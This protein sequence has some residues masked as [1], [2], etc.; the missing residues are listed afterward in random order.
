MWQAQPD[1]GVMTVYRAEE[2]GQSMVFING[3]STNDPDTTGKIW[4]LI[5]RRYGQSRRRLAVVNCHAERADRSRQ[6]ADACLTWSPADHYLVVGSGT[7]TFSQ[8]AMALGMDPDRVTCL[9]KVTKP[10][11]WRPWT[12]WPAARHWSWVWETSPAPGWTWCNIFANVTR[13][14]RQRVQ[15]PSIA[16]AGTGTRSEKW[17][18]RI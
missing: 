10:S 9:E 7:R 16:I 14:R 8:R 4:A 18:N 6:L 2:P 11:C 1:P 5:V 13:R 3:F 12:A 17:P 15:T